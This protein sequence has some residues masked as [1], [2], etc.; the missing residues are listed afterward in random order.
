MA[1]DAGV[2]AA[3]ETCPSVRNTIRSGR[4]GAAAVRKAAR[5]APIDPARKTRRWP[6]MSLVRPNTGRAM[7]YVRS[8]AVRTHVTASRDALNSCS[9]CG[10]ARL[11]TVIGN[12][13]ATIP[14]RAADRTKEGLAKGAGM[15]VRG[16]LPALVCRVGAPGRPTAQASSWS[17]RRRLAHPEAPGHARPETARRCD[18]GDLPQ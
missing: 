13:V 5:P 1:S 10:R 17:T 3:P 11:K 14:P 8:G 6:K 9:S 2:V 18:H 12:V 7:A 16:S 15:A 4:V